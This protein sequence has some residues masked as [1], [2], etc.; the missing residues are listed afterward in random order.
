MFLSTLAL[1]SVLASTPPS[2]VPKPEA[3]LRLCGL[4]QRDPRL[5]EMNFSAVYRLEFDADG[6]P[7][8]VTKL[9]DPA[10][11]EEKARACLSTWRV[12]NTGVGT[13]AYASLS[14]RWG[15]L[16]DVYLDLKDVRIR[17]FVDRP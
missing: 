7:V 9:K 11:G 15:L 16:H 13:T 10:L 1:L 3:E 17:V 2:A 5:S 8:T 12:R 4:E 6:V 14:W